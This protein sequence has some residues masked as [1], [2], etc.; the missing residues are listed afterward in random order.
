MIPFIRV[1]IRESVNQGSD[2]GEPIIKDHMELCSDC[3]RGRIE[4]E[5]NRSGVFLGEPK[6]NTAL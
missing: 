2:G 1:E 3:A 5:R 6:V 4:N